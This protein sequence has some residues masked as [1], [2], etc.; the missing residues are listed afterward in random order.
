MVPH[1]WTVEVPL[2]GMDEISGRD[3]FQEEIITLSFMYVKC[4]E[5]ERDQS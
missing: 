5:G 1:F 3:T 2:L 4:T